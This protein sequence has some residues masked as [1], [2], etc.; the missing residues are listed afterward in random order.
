LLRPVANTTTTTAATATK[1]TEATLG[2]AIPNQQQQIATTNNNIKTV[3]RLTDAK[4]AATAP[5][6]N[7]S[8]TSSASSLLLPQSSTYA[9]S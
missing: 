7:P 8:N 5:V 9:T 6:G 2:A 1:P 3:S 4:A